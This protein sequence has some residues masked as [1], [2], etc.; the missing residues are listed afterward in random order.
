MFPAP[1][2]AMQGIVYRDGLDKFLMDM[3]TGARKRKEWTEKHI[4]SAWTTLVNVWWV[5]VSVT[6]MLV[7]PLVFIFMKTG[8]FGGFLG[9]IFLAFVTAISCQKGG[10]IGEFFC[11]WYF[12]GIKLWSFLVPKEYRTQFLV[13]ARE[14][15]HKAI[16]S[17]IYCIIAW[18]YD[19]TS[20]VYLNINSTFHLFEIRPCPLFY[21]ILHGEW[22]PFESP[23]IIGAPIAYWELTR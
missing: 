13:E 7:S 23:P 17:F 4:S 12:F 11:G 10:V 8:F 6:M 21:G 19:D 9:F 14:G 15:I 16:F 18:A 5:V 2:R 20:R 1:K 22:T 3:G